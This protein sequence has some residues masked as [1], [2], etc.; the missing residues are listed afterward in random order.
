MSIEKRKM[1]IS[2]NALNGQS[3]VLAEQD[4]AVGIYI[5]GMI[6]MF[7]APVSE[8]NGPETINN[9]DNPVAG[10]IIGGALIAM[11]APAVI[12]IAYIHDIVSHHIRIGL[13]SEG[14]DGAAVREDPDG[15]EDPVITDI[16]I[17][18]GCG[19]GLVHPAPA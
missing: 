13:L 18:T 17:F 5:I 11:P 16:V 19:T 10:V 12:A 7:I 14:I 4:L 6:I 9:I 3:V 1:M 2:I 8:I 15:I